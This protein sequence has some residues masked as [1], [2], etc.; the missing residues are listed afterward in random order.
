[1]IAAEHSAKNSTSQMWASLRLGG[2]KA[3]QPICGRWIKVHSVSELIVDG[4]LMSKWSVFL[5]QVK[6]ALK[7]KLTFTYLS[8]AQ[9]SLWLCPSYS[10][11]PGR[12]R[13]W[14]QLEDS[15]ALW[16]ELMPWAAIESTQT[17]QLSSSRSFR[18]AQEEHLGEMHWMQSD[19][20]LQVLYLVNHI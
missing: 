17:W 12:G 4:C 16:D 20:L 3:L 10:N 7:C 9:P 8:K 5:K 6:T 13:V 18:H 15:R 19:A 2:F 11:V 1:M 14:K